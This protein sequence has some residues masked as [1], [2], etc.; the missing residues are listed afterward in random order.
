MPVVVNRLTV[1]GILSTEVSS[2]TL[3]LT[4]KIIDY[5][6]TQRHAIRNNKHALVKCRKV[7]N[8]AHVT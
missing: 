6:L 4:L 3:T 2:R 7:K 1:G 8:E 5:S